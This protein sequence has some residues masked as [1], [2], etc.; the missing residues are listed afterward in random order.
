MKKLR[1]DSG[2][3]NAANCFNN[4]AVKTNPANDPPNRCAPNTSSA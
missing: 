3:N 4:S 2:G 1:F